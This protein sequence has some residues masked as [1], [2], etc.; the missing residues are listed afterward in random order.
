MKIKPLFIILGV[1][2]LAGV[3]AIFLMPQGAANYKNAA[4]LIENQNVVLVN[5]VSEIQAVP[6]SASK[7]TTRIFGNEARGDLNGDGA[8][9]V[10]FILTQDS[11]GSGTFYYAVVALKTADGYKGTNGVLLGDR[12]APQTTEMRNGEVIVNYAERKPGEPMTAQPSVGISKYLKVQGTELAEVPG[13]GLYSCGQDSNCTLAEFGKMIAMNVKGKVI[14]PDSLAVSLNQINDSRCKAGVVCVWAGELSAS[15]EVTGGRLGASSKEIVI[16]TVRNKIVSSDGYVF[17]LVGATEESAAITVSLSPVVAYTSGIIGYLHLG[18]TCPV[19]RVPPDPSCAEK[20][21]ADAKVDIRLKSSGVLVKTLTSDAAGVFGTN[22]GSGVY[23][24]TA[25][26][27]TGGFLPRCNETEA[28]VTADQ[29]LS[30]DIS[31][32][33]G[34]R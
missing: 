21:Y 22:L 6:G 29:V 23:T 1:L 25:G 3:L 30:V 27:M 24:I 16:G 28:T 15:L 8:E 32:D 31:C 17:T 14:F 12:I 2:V 33:T 26:P 7:I 9:D 5:G 13:K 20:P 10:A 19:E 18:P 34:I 4:Y 11:G